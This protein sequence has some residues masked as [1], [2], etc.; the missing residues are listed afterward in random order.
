MPSN[1]LLYLVVAL[2]VAS[3]AS[4]VMAYEHYVSDPGPVTPRKN[5][6]LNLSLLASL[7]LFVALAYVVP[8]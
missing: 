6:W 8:A 5:W 2:W 3:M 4:A 7:Y 1:P